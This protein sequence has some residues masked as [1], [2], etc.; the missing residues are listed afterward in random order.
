MVSIGTLFAFLLVCVAVLHLRRIAPEATR[1]FR[2]PGVPWLPLL[3]IGFSL[4]LMLGL[5][6]TTWLRLVVWLALGLLLYFGYGHR[7][8]L[9]PNT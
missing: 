2:A 7:H 4:L 5:P 1:P 6:L 9:A 8:S 3:G